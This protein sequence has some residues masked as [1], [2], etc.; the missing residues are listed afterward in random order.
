MMR[1]AI[2]FA[3]VFALGVAVASQAG[4]AL[5]GSHPRQ[6]LQPGPAKLA[7]GDLVAKLS[8]AYGPLSADENWYVGS[9]VCLACHQEYSG[10]KETKHNQALRQP[11]PEYTMIPGKG[12]VADYDQNGVDDFQQGLD[13][14]TISS[15]FDKYKPNAPKLS[16]E[17]GKYYIT[18]GTLKMPVVFTQGGTGSWKQRFGVRIPVSDLASGLSAEIYMSPIQYNEKT[19]QYVLYNDKN[20]YDQ[21]TNQPKWAAGVTSAQLASHG[22]TYSKNCIGCHATGIRDLGQTAT[23]EWLY[24]GWMATVYDPADP[25][26][27]DYDGDGNADLV[28]IGCESCHGPGLR[29]VL[30]GGA[31]DKIVNPEKL[32]TQAANEVCGQCH[33]R[34]A[35]VPNGTHEWPYNDATKKSWVP[36]SGEPLANYYED[37]GGYWPDGIN[38]KQHHQQ[39]PDLYRSTKP[40]F[41]F[42]PVRCTEC[43]DPHR[44]TANPHQIVEHVVSDNVTIATSNDN[45]TLCLACHATHGP[46]ADITKEQVAN[47]EENMDHIENVVSAHTHHPYGPERSMGLS[48]CSKCHMPTVATSAVAYDIHS[49]TFEVIPPEKTLKYQE[50]GGMPNACAVSCHATKVNSF[51]LGLDPSI[52]T[53]NADF[54]KALATKLMVY[55]GPNGLWWPKAL[56]PSQAPDARGYR[57]PA[58]DN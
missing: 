7:A 48:R 39:F 5:V 35:S 38:S 41:Q 14:N 15:P 47:L 53:W 58:D 40:T 18:I 22:G 36:G 26:V 37:H 54:D 16:F 4:T 57:P 8:V 50:Q 33:I 2:V 43:H 10:W 34:V 21:T 3:V 13:F 20:W 55:Y 49:H 27:F 52:G 44:N 46:F 32:S 19:H 56:T 30:G 42:H 17:G 51:G 11:R 23:G 28:N 24:R 25:G 29:H 9:Y 31:P 12:V 6:W 45:N 1:K